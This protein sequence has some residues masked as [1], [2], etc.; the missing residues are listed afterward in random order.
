VAA[1]GD[2]E[3][4]FLV[5]INASNRRESTITRN[6]SGI[7]GSWSLSLGLQAG[8]GMPVPPD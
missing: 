5:R 6:P 8:Q 4:V 3:H 7:F 2:S 1:F